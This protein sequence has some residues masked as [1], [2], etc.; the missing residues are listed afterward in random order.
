MKI[1]LLGALLFLI[2]FAGGGIIAPGLI[3][4]QVGGSPGLYALASSAGVFRYSREEGT[5]AYKFDDKVHHK[6][7]ESRWNR[8]MRELV[9]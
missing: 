5:K 8:A 2:P 7:I 1:T 6:T 4:A 3:F 9:R